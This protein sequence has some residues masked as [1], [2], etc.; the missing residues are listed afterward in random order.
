MGVKTYVQTVDVAEKKIIWELYFY[1]M[2]TFD[3]LNK[4]FKG[5]YRYSQLK[6]IILERLKDGNTK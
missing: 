4:Y 1:N 3:D 5:K 2:F 6:S